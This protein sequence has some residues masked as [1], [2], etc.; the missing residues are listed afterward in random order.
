MKMPWPIFATSSDR[1]VMSLVQAVTEK[2]WVWLL[3][4]TEVM[5]LVTGSNRKVMS[6]VTGS[7]R[8]VMSLVTGCNRKVMSLVTG[9][10][11]K[12][13]SLVTGCNRKVMSLVTGIFA[14][15]RV[16]IRVPLLSTLGGS[17]IHFEIRAQC[18]LVVYRSCAP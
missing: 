2:S 8:K 9:C 7:N 17:R 3:T 14:S 16:T 11:R 13:K 4:V 18:H 5:S 10:N 12:V 1:N 6:L 15:Q